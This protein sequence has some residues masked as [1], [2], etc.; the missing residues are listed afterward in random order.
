MDPSLS[1]ATSWPFTPTATL[2]PACS[3]PTPALNAMLI[4]YIWRL[5]NIKTVLRRETSRGKKEC[6]EKKE[7]KK[8]RIIN[9]FCAI[10]R[11]EW[12]IP[13]I[14]FML[15]WQQLR[16]SELGTRQ[17]T[18]V[19][20]KPWV[21]YFGN[22]FGNDSSVC[23]WLDP[24]LAWNYKHC[25][26]CNEKIETVRKQH[27]FE[28]WPC[29]CLRPYWNLGLY[30]AGLPTLRWVRHVLCWCPLGRRGPGNPR[31]HWLTKIIFSPDTHNWA[32]GALQT[33]LVC[34]AILVG[35]WGISA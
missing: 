32:T 6:G 22:Y 33:I 35:E 4:L 24:S 26:H 14:F 10:K 18:N 3:P 1:S 34:S 13:D 31:H 2:P 23:F 21:V 30:I 17:S 27:D 11:Y 19:I 16:F 29:K 12:Q 8:S 9:H 25:N 7:K 15:W 5:A 28:I 20:C